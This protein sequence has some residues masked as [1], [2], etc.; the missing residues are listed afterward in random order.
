MQKKNL[1][2]LIKL[3]RIDMNKLQLN[4]MMPKFVIYKEESAIVRIFSKERKI[5]LI[6][7][8]TQLILSSNLSKQV[9]SLSINIAKRYLEWIDLNQESFKNSPRI[10]KLL[11]KTTD[12]PHNSKNLY[13]HILLCLTTIQSALS[14]QT[15]WP[16]KYSRTAMMTYPA[17]LSNKSSIT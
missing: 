6:R 13:I 9:P 11:M 12:N 5:K 16:Q 2:L 4:N 10:W 14:Q 1:L 15:K 8:S 3:R 7:S 17:A